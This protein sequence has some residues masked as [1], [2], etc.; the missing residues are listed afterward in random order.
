MRDYDRTALHARRAR[1][2]AI[3]DMIGRMTEE[4]G[5][6]G[7]MILDHNER[8]PVTVRLCDCVYHGFPEGVLAND[9]ELD[10]WEVLGVLLALRTS[11]AAHT[12]EI[13]TK[14]VGAA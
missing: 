4:F 11:Y 2:H 6:L 14:L 1:L 10:L 8:H 3:D 12:A 13:E 9:V 5:D 7:E